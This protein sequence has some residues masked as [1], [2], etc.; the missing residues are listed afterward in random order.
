ML[1]ILIP[2]P[3]ETQTLKNH[4]SLTTSRALEAPSV[5]VYVESEAQREGT[6]QYVTASCNKSSENQGSPLFWSEVRFLVHLTSSA[7]VS[8]SHPVNADW[9][10]V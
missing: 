6:T 7:F 2:F 9:A 10:R 5:C 4:R 1:R 8:P 3:V